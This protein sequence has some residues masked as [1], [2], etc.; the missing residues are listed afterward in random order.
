MKDL[1]PW[2]TVAAVI[3]DA[4]DRAV[5]EPGCR[6]R[7]EVYRVQ[8]DGEPLPGAEI[9]ALYWLPQPFFG[10]PV[11]IGSSAFSVASRVGLSIAASACNPARSNSLFFVS[12]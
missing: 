11:L 9:E 12:R 10:R 1:P 8:V 3:T 6:V 7:A 4:E 2:Q 5:N